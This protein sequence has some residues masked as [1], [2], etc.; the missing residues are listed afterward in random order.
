MSRKRPSHSEH[1]TSADHHHHEGGAH[2][3]H[4]HHHAGGEPSRGAL[5]PKRS[6][7]GAL[8]RGA[9]RGK[10]L[11]L[12][13]P[14][15]LAG[16][17]IIAALIDLGVPETVVV[18]AVAALPITGYRLHFGSRERSG[19]VAGAFD[20]EVETGQPSRD[21]R[22][23]RAMLEASDLSDGIRSR[24]LAT[25]ER[26]ALAESRVHAMPIDDV[27][28]HEVGAIDAIVD[29]VGSAA[30]LEYLEARLLVSPLPMGRGVVR[31]AHGDLPMPTP[32]TVSCLEGLETV[33]DPLA[34]EFVTPTGAAICGAHAR[35]STHW[36]SMR[37]ERVG[38]GSGT[39]DLP[40]RP[41]VLRAVLG[42][43]LP[44][45]ATGGVA[46]HVVVEATIDDATGELMGLALDAVREAGARD[47]WCVPATMRKSRPGL[48]LSAVAPADRQ[49]AVVQAIFEHTTT[50]GVRVLPASRVERERELVTVETAFGSVPVKV[51]RGHG[52]AVHVKPEFDACVELAARSNV[53]VKRVIA[54][55]TA[56]ALEKA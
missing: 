26:L 1:S 42:E 11:F 13:A 22:A 6:A 39:A 8:P 30:Q 12:D 28:F 16:D 49:S 2:H 37:P 53:P 3:H 18:E 40:D 43:S 38:W 41:N 14:S 24:A 45:V 35:S 5:G 51:S 50:I 7:R 34:F 20:V 17:M 9:G 29:V 47:V 46:T 36:P 25:F 55:A 31:A 44:D 54:E 21:Y 10:I 4:H 52:A 32:A 23:I 56:K 15:G 27:H 19:I 33:G 48:V